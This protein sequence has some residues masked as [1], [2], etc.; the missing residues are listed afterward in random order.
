MQGRIQDLKDYADKR[1]DQVKSILTSPRNEQTMKVGEALS[2]IV[3]EFGGPI[4]TDVKKTFQSP[5]DVSTVKDSLASIVRDL[6]A[7]MPEAQRQ[8]SPGYAAVKQILSGPDTI[9]ALTADKNLGALKSLLRQEGSGGKY[10]S[11]KSQGLARTAISS[12][13]E[14]VEDTLKDAGGSVAPKLFQAR[15]AV[16]SYYDTAELLNSLPKNAVGDYE[17]AAVFQRLTGGTGDRNGELLKNLQQYAPKEMKEI[18]RTWLQGLLDQI[19]TEGGFQRAQGAFGK[20]QKMGPETRKVLLG[21][22]A[23]DVEKFLLGAKRLTTDINPSGTAKT[24]L[25]TLG[26]LAVVYDM[27]TGS[28]D[29]MDRLKKLPRDLAML[30]AAGYTSNTLA[31]LLFEPNAAKILTQGLRINATSGAMIG[32]RALGTG[33]LSRLFSPS[34]PPQNPLAP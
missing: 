20:F 10:L 29:T 30:A 22:Q 34:Q 13:T 3:D 1:Y 15:K 26:P 9:D 25:A 11:T 33:S 5:V 32:T 6:D 31:R 16:Q 4:T 7:A 21:S 24:G 12:L 28:G 19:T 8:A 2:P 17:P 14:A 23:D 27:A 18:G